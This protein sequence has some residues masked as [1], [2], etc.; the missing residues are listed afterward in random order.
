MGH[1]LAPPGAAKQIGFVKRFDPRWWTVNFPRPMMAAVV[2]TAP[3]ALRVDAVFYKADDLAGLIWEAEDRFD[4]PLLAYATDRDFRFCRLGFRWRSGGIRA[5]D[6]V[7]GPTL[8]IEGRDPA[9]VAHSWYVRLW[10][11]ADGTPEDALVALDFAALAGGWAGEDPV[12]AGDIDRMFVSM[13]APGYSGEDAPLAAPA[14]GW[15]EL[16]GIACDGA[17]SVLAV[18]DALVPEHRLRI[19]TGYD[20]LY[21]L[22]PARLLRNCLQL[23]YRGPINHYV[24]MSHYFRL[25]ASGGGYH[26]SLAGGVLNAPC[27]AWHRDFCERA[28]SL[29]FEPILSL[30]YELLDQ[31]AWG[32]WKQRAEDGAPALTGWSPPSTLLSPAHD[33]A[34]SYLRLVAQAFAGIAAA[35]GLRV[36]FQIGEPWWWVMPD[37]RICLYDAAAVAQFAPVS[38]AD[39]RAPLS[40]AQQATLDEAGA[41]LAQSTAALT[42]AVRSV[43]ADAETLLLV[44]LP[45]VLASPDLRLANLPLDWASPAFDRLQLEDY[46]WVTAGNAGATASGVGQATARLGYPLAEQHYFAGFV[47]APEDEAQWHRIAAAA[48]AAR[49]RGTGEVFVWALPQVL[50][51]GFTWFEGGDADMDAF[52]DV[53]FPVALGREASVEPAFSTAVATSASGAEQRNSDWADARLRFDAGPGV[54]GEADL[55]ALIAFFRARR[56][57]AVAFRFE[58]PFDNSSNGMTGEPGPADQV[59]GVGDGVRTDFALVKHYGGQQRRITRPAPGTVRVSVGGVERIGGWI[60][61]PLGLVRFDLAPAEGAEVE[62]G[63]RFDVPVRFAEDRLAVGRAT[64]E[65]GE[66]PSVPLLEVREG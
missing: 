1:W 34:M 36:R 33:G 37:G 29:G 20:D 35:A 44:Y 59:L 50:R 41:V 53:R 52:E 12:W 15:A 62:A 23:G 51:D 16:S 6:A 13:V 43:A 7:N 21:H 19:A 47:P 64:F 45:S 48:A 18:G 60:L 57:A 10:N 17:G 14:E 56:G 4:H 24:G 61:A 54:R 11:Y 3:D 58:D 42:A 32:D 46:E 26:V 25:E 30:S 22:T 55:H 38:I 66:I 9:G 65:A 8:T 28:G 27:A 63:F 39:V 5:L 49:A 2:T 31:H 40:E